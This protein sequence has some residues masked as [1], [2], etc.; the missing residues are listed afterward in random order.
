MSS[1]GHSYVDLL[2]L[3]IEGF[4]FDVLGDFSETHMKLPR[5]IAVE[6]HYNLPTNRQQTVS[7]VADMSLFALH[8]ANL[9]YGIV[10]L[11]P[12]KGCHFCAEFGLLLVEHSKHVAI[13]LHHNS[14]S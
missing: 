14:T 9:G 13:E 12:N 10:G 5:Q 8:L 1:L 3:D 4:E 7:S 6:T 11:E 2:K